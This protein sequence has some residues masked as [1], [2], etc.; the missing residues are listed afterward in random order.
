MD[1]RRGLIRVWIV[2]S[3]VW[4]LGCGWRAV[5]S[6]PSIVDPAKEHAKRAAEWAERAEE[7]KRK[8]E[9]SLWCRLAGEFTSPY[10][11]PTLEEQREQRLRVW[12]HYG[13]WLG[14]GIAGPL[15]VLLAGYVVG[16]IM[17]GFRR[18]SRPSGRD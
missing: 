18:D 14:V 7:C 4:V 5:E 10:V 1:I 15:G 16:W 13:R 17:R 12:Y 9:Q 3:V 11:P 2:L 6:Q 8:P